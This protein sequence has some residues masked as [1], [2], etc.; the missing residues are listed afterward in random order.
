M[1][2]ATGCLTLQVQLP[3]SRP[4]LRR[5]ITTYYS[6]TNNS[7]SAHQPAGSQTQANEKGVRGVTLA[8]GCANSRLLTFY[9]WLILYLE[10]LFAP[11]RLVHCLPL[12]S[13]FL[14]LLLTLFVLF[15]PVWLYL[16]F[17]FLALSH[18]PFSLLGLTKHPPQSHSPSQFSTHFILTVD[19]F[20]D[21]CKSRYCI[22]LLTSC[23]HLT[24]SLRWLILSLTP[25]RC[26]MLLIKG[27]ENVPCTEIP[28][29]S[30]LSPQFTSHNFIPFYFMFLPLHVP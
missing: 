25:S 17:I 16:K 20:T 30:H 23:H 3:V 26:L 9:Q 2:L 12:F 19:T 1:Y 18:P 15:F 8:P 11:C 28:S 22:F 10:N 5:G 21:G 7:L 13:V 6:S 14:P 24:F 29:H 27:L 4:H